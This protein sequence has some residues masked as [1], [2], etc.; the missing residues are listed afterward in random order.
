M[1]RGKSMGIQQIA[2]LR[3]QLKPARMQVQIPSDKR[4][5]TPLP[6]KHPGQ[7]LQDTAEV[8]HFFQAVSLSPR[9]ST[10]SRVSEGLDM[11]SQKTIINKTC[12]KVRQYETM[13]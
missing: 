3:L 6:F 5:S 2:A 12:H 13:H 7:A 4:I 9:K 8:Q 11:N 10:V 1:V